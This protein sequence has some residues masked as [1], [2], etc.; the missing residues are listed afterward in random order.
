MANSG[1]T[2]VFDHITL[3]VTDVNRS[4]EF[5]Q[6]VFNFEEIENRT[7]REGIRW[8]SF[9]EGKELHLNSLYKSE[10]KLLHKAVHLA[11]TTAD[12]DQFIRDLEAM[13][14][15]Y[16][17]WPGNINQI[18]IRADGIKQV[19]IQDPDGYWIEINNVVEIANNGAGILG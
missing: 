19:Y 4:V 8:L 9:G 7:R 18:N 3:L 10:F 17:D 2:L 6:L 11:V 5:Y 16:T 14:V 12:F 15:T 1:Y 13:N